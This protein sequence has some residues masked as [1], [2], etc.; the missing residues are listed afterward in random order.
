MNR[1]VP[2]FPAIPARVSV[3]KC[4]IKAYES[5]KHTTERLLATG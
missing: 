4:G 3:M 2:Y 1:F 5:R